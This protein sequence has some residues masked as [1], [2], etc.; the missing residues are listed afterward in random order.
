[1]KKLDPE[2][3]GAWQRFYFRG[4]GYLCTTGESKVRRKGDDPKYKVFE[5]CVCSS[6]A[7]KSHCI[8]PHG[9]IKQRA[10]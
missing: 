2:I 8:K 4:G 5:V 7:N 10:R 1:M 9:I 6:S 3:Y